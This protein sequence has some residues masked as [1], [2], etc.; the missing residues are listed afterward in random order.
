MTQ[1]YIYN[2]GPAEQVLYKGDNSETDDEAQAEEI[3][4]ACMIIF[5][6][7]YKNV[8]LSYN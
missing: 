8:S 5:A 2:A 4:K 7:C 6:N 1:F 3:L